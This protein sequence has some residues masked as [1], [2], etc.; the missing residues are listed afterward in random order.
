M[1]MTVNQ[2]LK[3]RCLQISPPWDMPIDLVGRYN[4]IVCVAQAMPVDRF[5]STEPRGMSRAIASVV[6]RWFCIFLPTYP[7]RFWSKEP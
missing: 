7:R 6:V 1:P 3:Q 5:C 2:A 4:H